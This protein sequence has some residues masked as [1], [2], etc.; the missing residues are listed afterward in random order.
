MFIAEV[1]A[2]SYLTCRLGRTCV[3]LKTSFFLL[4]TSGRDDERG[5]LAV[6]AMRVYSTRICADETVSQSLPGQEVCVVSFP[7]S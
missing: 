5:G 1:L 4:C 7:Y 2:H 6:V 3:L